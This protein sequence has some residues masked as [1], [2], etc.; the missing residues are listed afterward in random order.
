MIDSLFTGDFL[1]QDSD[2]VF[3]YRKKVTRSFEHIQG[4]Y[5]IAP[6]FMDKVVVHITKNFMAHLLPTNNPLIL[7]IWGGKGQGKTFQ[8]ELI[9]RAMG[10]EPVIL[11]AGE[12]ESEWAGRVIATAV[13][14]VRGEPGKLIRNRY[15]T[16]SQVIKNQGKLS[17]LVIN[18]VDAGVG[19]FANTQVTVNNQIVMGTL[20]NLADCPTRVSIGQDWREADVVNRVPIILTGND[21]STLWA[22]LIR[23]GRMDKFYW[24]PTKTDILNI[25]HHMYR[26]DGLSVE[27]I[28]YIIDT[29]PG[30]ALDFYGALRS[31][32][33]DEHILKWVEDI[34]GTDKLHERLVSKKSRESP[35]AVNPPKPTVEA[36]V[37]AGKALEMEQRMVTDI[38]LS[39]EYM[40]VMTGSGPGLS[41]SK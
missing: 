18:D 20:M 25:V 34:G 33:Y 31:R 37:E 12:L 1:G 19:R 6:S 11:S 17:C 23:D 32:L 13:D 3:D 26:N 7:G 41:L 8:I 35:P 9:F 40:P 16:A 36:L 4:D 38:R 2:I 29:F 10:V 30:Q 5:Y 39:E 27:D 21:F 24:R 22:P 28:S 15:R 14:Q